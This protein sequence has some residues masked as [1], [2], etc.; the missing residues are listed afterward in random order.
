MA[1]VQKAVRGVFER[2]AGSDSWWIHYYDFVTVSVV[3]RR[4][5]G[6]GMRLI[7]T[8]NVSSRCWQV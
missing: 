5:V 8:T 3:E 2:P 1:R 7:S 6:T 4:L